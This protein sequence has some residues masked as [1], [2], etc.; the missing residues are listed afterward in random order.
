MDSIATP[1]PFLIFGGVGSDFIEGG[2]DDDEISGDAPSQQ[3]GT[4]GSDNITASLKFR[5]YN[6]FHIR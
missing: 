6:Y 2:L 3:I 4:S 5:I 1:N